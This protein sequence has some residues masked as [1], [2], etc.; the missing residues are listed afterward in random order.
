MFDCERSFSILRGVLI[1]S[2]LMTTDPY[3]IDRWYEVYDRHVRPHAANAP[4]H[5]QR[6][7]VPE[8]IAVWNR[9]NPGQALQSEDRLDLDKLKAATQR[10]LTAF[11]GSGQYISLPLD[12]RVDLLM[13]KPKPK[14]VSWADSTPSAGTVPG[15][16]APPVGAAP[17]HA[18][19]E[20]SAL[21]S[22]PHIVAP[23]PQSYEQQTQQPKTW[24]AAHFPPPTHGE[25]EMK[26]PMNTVY[27][28]AWEQPKSVQSSYFQQPQESQSQY[29]TLPANVRGDDWY[30]EFTSTVP[31]RSNVQAVFPW[32]KPG[33]QR[34]PT[35]VF[36]KG[37]T[38][39]PEKQHRPA[40]HLSV[41]EATP[42]TSPVHEQLT[43]TPAPATQHRSM[44]EAMAS[45][46]N[47]WDADPRIERYVNRL[48]G[49]PPNRHHDRH[50]SRDYGLVDPGALQSMPGTPKRAPTSWLGQEA[51]KK[52]DASDDGDDEDDGESEA[53]VGDSPTTTRRRARLPDD[54][55]L[56]PQP[57]GPGF[58]KS[59]AKYR[60]R[61][62]QTDRPDFNDAKVQAYPEGPISPVVPTRPL[63]PNT[64]SSSSTITAKGPGRKGKLA[65]SRASSSSDTAKA[66]S[67]IVTPMSASQF[68]SSA[69]RRS[70]PFPTYSPSSGSILP[71]SFSPT[72]P[73]SSSTDAGR[74]TRVSRIFDP[75]TDVDV[76]KRDTQQVLS[77]FM[78]VGAFAR[79]G[80]AGEGGKM[81]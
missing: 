2:T 63:L 57:E 17:P 59:N 43:P 8:H 4:D 65:L 26:I 6:F 13:P 22:P 36:P 34:A 24:D 39:P 81:A 55:A 9:E 67:T 61:H 60:D 16:P 3:L 48:T 31:D 37:D 80:G 45:Y 69:E 74:S 42:E 49:G 1:C 30:K 58:Y 52:S 77:R 70:V 56:F 78:Q 29:P 53:S 47:A 25:P 76:R 44:A 73:S 72:I 41:Q 19:S 66:P 62:V 15:Q 7:A 54:S 33:N 50:T 27:A 5:A 11:Q 28:P 38:P 51:A 23:L 12:G 68:P 75:S 14:R 18:Q 32:E 64:S 35:R 79:T 40:V 46:K 21:S 10:G 20:P 71:P